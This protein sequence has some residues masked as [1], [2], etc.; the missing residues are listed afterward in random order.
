[1]KL[2]DEWNIITQIAC[3]IT[4]YT[5]A[6]DHIAARGK[7]KEMLEELVRLRSIYGE[8]PYI[9]EITAVYTRNTNKKLSLFEL[10]YSLSS[11]TSEYDE[12]LAIATSAFE[13]CLEDKLKN[14]SEIWRARVN[15]LLSKATDSELLHEANILLNEEYQ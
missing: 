12:S 13:F 9:I 1:M 4:N 7:R 11:S 5:I 2:K 14:Q 10:A 6:N 3:D 15:G 8:I